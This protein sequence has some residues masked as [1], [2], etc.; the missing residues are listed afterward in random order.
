MNAPR[1]GL[2]PP[3]GPG[4]IVIPTI[5]IILIDIDL[6][7]IAPSQPVTLLT[8]CLQTLESMM[9]LIKKK[10]RSTDQTLPTWLSS[11]LGKTRVKQ[12][13]KLLQASIAVL[14]TMTLNRAAL[15]SEQTQPVTMDSARQLSKGVCKRRQNGQYL[16]SNK[17]SSPA[18]GV[19]SLSGNLRTVSSAYATTVSR[20]WRL[21]VL[22]QI[23]I[24]A[25]LTFWSLKTQ[26]QSLSN[27]KRATNGQ[28][29]SSLDKAKDGVVSAAAK[30]LRSIK[31]KFD[32]KKKLKDNG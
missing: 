4:I 14:T 7:L 25:K 19:K 1:R 10:Y 6:I 22:K 21:C 23:A 2:G 13:N 5:I 12:A 26:R 3:L 32:N 27:A 28:M 8:Q 18:T 16:L 31:H 11:D 15:M 24:V 9:T 17:L 30:K 20:S 29:I